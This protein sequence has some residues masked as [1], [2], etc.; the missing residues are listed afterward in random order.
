MMLKGNQVKVLS[1]PVTVIILYPNYVIAHGVRRLGRIWVRARNLLN[2]GKFFRRK[3][4]LLS[5][6]NSCYKVAVDYWLNG[7]Y[8]GIKV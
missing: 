1:N 4:S 7:F 6:F 3:I 2:F 8:H 5:R